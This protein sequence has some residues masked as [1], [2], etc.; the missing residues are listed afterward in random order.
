VL[1]KVFRGKFIDLL[2]QAHAEHA[3]HGISDNVALE[4]LISASVGTDWVVYAKPP[5]GGPRQ[6]LKYLSRY[7]HRIAIS[8]SRL[9]SMGENSVTFRW[10]DYAHGN[11][12]KAMTLEAGEFLRRFLMHVVPSG[13]MRIRHFGL[14]S[15]R[16]RTANIAHCRHLLATLAPGEGFD[17]SFTIMALENPHERCP[18]CGKGLMIRGEFIHPT[19]IRSTRFDTS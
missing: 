6:V 15:N 13:F 5:F 17:S 14:F 12:P 11:Q 19:V 7:T 10:K 3:L 1:S 4:A 2:K 8:N 16:F 18:V 9:V